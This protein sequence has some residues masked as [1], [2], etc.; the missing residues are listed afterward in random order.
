MNKSMRSM[1]LLQ[2]DLFGALPTD[3]ISAKDG[4]VHCTNRC[5]QALLVESWTTMGAGWLAKKTYER[6]KIGQI[7]YIPVIKAIF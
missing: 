6:I 2:D 5:F 1:A 4:V 3:L 7:G